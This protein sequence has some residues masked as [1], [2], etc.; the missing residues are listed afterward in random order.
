M[1]AGREHGK[2]GDQCH[3]FHICTNAGK[4]RRRRRKL[5]KG[6]E[7]EGSLLLLLLLPPPLPY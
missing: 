3:S 2:G 4:A 1:R 5:A 7:G 6:R